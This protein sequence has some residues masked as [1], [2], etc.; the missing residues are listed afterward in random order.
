MAAAD[1]QVWGA[2]LLTGHFTELEQRATVGGILIERPK[3]HNG[4]ELAQTA[5]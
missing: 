1:D 4:R 2:S 5:C 3:V